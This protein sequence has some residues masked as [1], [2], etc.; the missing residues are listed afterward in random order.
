MAAYFVYAF[1]D[2]TRPGDFV[3]GDLRFTSEP[4]Y[5]GK[6]SG[7]RLQWHRYDPKSTRNRIKWGVIERIRK[8]G[9][10]YAVVNLVEGLTEDEAF[11]LE[12]RAIAAIGRRNKGTGPLTNLTDGGEG[13]SG[14]VPSEAE[15]ERRRKASAG[16]NNPMYGKPTYG[17]KG[18][19]HTAETK[20]IIQEKATGVEVDGDTRELLSSK[21][22]QSWA[23]GRK[24]RCRVSVFGTIHTSIRQASIASG[25]N[26]ETLLARIKAGVPGYLELK[27]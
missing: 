7:R 11:A 8:A 12:V 23:K 2:P 20:K 14:W 27:N 6:G 17:F 13:A 4:F 26:R 15:L 25:I 5:V 16:S 3:Y 22:A 1:L 9:L 19:L 21:T 10:E 18:K 24:A